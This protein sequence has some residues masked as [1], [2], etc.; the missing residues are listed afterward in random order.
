MPATEVKPSAVELEFDDAAALDCFTS[1]SKTIQEELGVRV[2]AVPSY[3][4]MVL[5][6]IT[7]IPCR[8]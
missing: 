2:S 7:N 8:N 3:T 5:N 4:R 6:G 1:H